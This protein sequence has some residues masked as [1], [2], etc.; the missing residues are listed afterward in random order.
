MANEL[1]ELG[2]I[3]EQAIADDYRRLRMIGE[4]IHR[5]EHQKFGTDFYH[6]SAVYFLKVLET[7]GYTVT[8]INNVTEDKE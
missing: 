3:S 7:M 5:A 8:K 2:K 4:A 6:D 1:N